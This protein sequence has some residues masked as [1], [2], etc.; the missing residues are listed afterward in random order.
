MAAAVD[1]DDRDD[2]TSAALLLRLFE[3]LQA[4]EL[5][6]SEAAAWFCDSVV[7]WINGGYPGRLF[8]LPRQSTLLRMRNVYLRQ[9]WNLVICEKAG[10][11]ARAQALLDEVRRFQQ[12]PTCPAPLPHWSKVRVAIWNADQLGRL[13]GTWEQLAA[14]CNH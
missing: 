5:P 11:M 6:D 10:P 13:P 8:G 12:R 4:G 7:E 1:S 14:I 2:K 3:S 9:A